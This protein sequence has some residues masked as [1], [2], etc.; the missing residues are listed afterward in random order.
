MGTLLGGQGPDST[1]NFA[2]LDTVKAEAVG[3]LGE[4]ARACLGQHEQALRLQT[5]TGEVIYLSVGPIAS[6]RNL[7]VL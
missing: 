4:A 7:L 5:M 2:E 6:L 1:C 3:V